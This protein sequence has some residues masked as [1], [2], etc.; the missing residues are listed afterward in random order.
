VVRASIDKPALAKTL[1]LRPQQKIIP[2]IPIVIASIPF[3][4][5]LRDAMK[6][7]F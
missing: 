7:M 6:L 2:A 3:D 1:N 4:T 5:V